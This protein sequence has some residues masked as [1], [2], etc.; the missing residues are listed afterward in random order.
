MRP[1]DE[2]LLGHAPADDAGPADLIFLGDRDARAISGG[3]P[4]RPYAARA[5]T[6]HE[7]VEVVPSEASSL[8]QRPSR[9]VERQ[10]IGVVGELARDIL[11]QFHSEL[12]E[13]IDVRHHRIGERPMLVESDQRAQGRGS[14]RSSR[15]V[16]LG[17]LPA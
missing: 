13:G 8:D 16:V 12:I 7:Q 9:R 10:V 3:D 4:R 6:D 11:A 2:Q 1:I 5:G 17:R 15:M 14:R